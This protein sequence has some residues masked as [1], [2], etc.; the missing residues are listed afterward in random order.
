VN[1][2]QLTPGQTVNWIMPVGRRHHSHYAWRG[3]SLRVPATVLSVGKKTVKIQIE[4][5]ERRVKPRQLEARTHVCT[6]P[7]CGPYPCPS[8]RGCPFPDEFPCPR[9][10]IADITGGDHA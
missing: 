9:H 2:N 3:T 1:L 4:G 5:E 6:T 8:S 7:G 10:F